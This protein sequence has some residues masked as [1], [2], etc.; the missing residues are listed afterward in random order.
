MRSLVN[1]GIGI[2]AG[3]ETQ[4]DVE[5]LAVSGLGGRV[6][7][8][9]V[10]VVDEDPAAAAAHALALD[11]ALDAAGIDAPRLHHGKGPATWAVMAQA[12]A[13]GRDVR[14]GLEDVLTLPN[15]DPTPDNATLVNA[16]Q[17][18]RRAA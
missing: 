6:L 13:L 11:R 4:A 14:V 9:L 8:V 12:E 10:E 16:A 17:A 18:L 5:R 1:V 15:G 2:E 3:I 7:R